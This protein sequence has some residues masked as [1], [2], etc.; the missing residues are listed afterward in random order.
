MK[1]INT[2]VNTNGPLKAGVIKIY[3]NNQHFQ[4]GALHHLNE[5]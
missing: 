2:T 3:T 4:W 1:F 5:I